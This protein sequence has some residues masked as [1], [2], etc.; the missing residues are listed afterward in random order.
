MPDLAAH[1]HP[2]RLSVTWLGHAT[3]LV[4]TDGINVLTDPVFDRRVSPLPG[5]GPPRHRPPPLS[6]EQLPHIDLVA[7]SHG[8]YD[9]LSLAA[10]RGL[11]RQPGGPPRFLLPRGLDDW[12]RRHVDRAA[13]HHILPFDWWQEREVCGVATT[14][15][16]VQ[17]WTARTLWDKN[18]TLW[19][20]WAFASPAGRFLFAGDLGYSADIA[21]IGRQFSGWELAA[22]PIGAYD[23]QWLMRPYHL[24]PADA[25]RVHRELRVQRSL[26]IHW[27]TYENLTDEPLDEPPERLRAAQGEAGLA[28]DSFLVGPP[29]STWDSPL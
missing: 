10:M 28:H 7:I 23:P 27:G 17:H 14:F 3:V 9:H 19:G 8:H 12:F 16:P 25:V 11:Y 18:R 21:A 20:A 4:S 13:G 1:G 24:T 26:A 2:G 29:G 22:L 5:F 15:L 6:L